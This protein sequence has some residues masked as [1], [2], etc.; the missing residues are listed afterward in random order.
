VDREA[1]SVTEDPRYRVIF[2]ST[3]VLL[4]MIC[5]PVGLE[6]APFA[7]DFNNCLAPQQQGLGGFLAESWDRLGLIRSA[8]FVEIL[9]TTGVC[10]TLPFGVAIALS[11]ALYV[12]VGLALRGLLRDLGIPV[13]WAEI[14]GAL[15]LL[16]PLGTEVALW[17][18]GL[19]VP[20]GLLLTLLALRAWRRGRWILGA[21]AA[22]AACL[23]VEQVILALPLAALLVAPTENRRTA[24]LTTGVIV[25][26][27]A[28][29]FAVFPGNDPR[30]QAGVAE[31]LRGVF[32]DPSFYA[33]YPAVGLGLHSIPLALKWALPWAAVVVGVGAA[34]GYRVLGPRLRSETTRAARWGRD[35]ALLAGLLILLNVPVI[36]NVPRQ[37][38]PRVFAPTWLALAA[39]SAIFGAR[40]RVRSGRALGALIGSV[41]T[42]LLLSIALSVS[43]RT[44]SGDF[45]RWSSG[46]IAESTNDSDVV[47]LCGVRRTVVTTAPRGA[48]AVHDFIYDW[49]AQDAVRYYTDRI[50]T[51]RLGGELLGSSCPSPAEVDVHLEFDRLVTS[52]STR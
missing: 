1:L 32:T 13:L 8:R 49:A 46:R 9:I 38:S 19:H 29:A 39:G 37:G 5:L 25:G 10:Q 48:F 28:V 11:F 35:L 51:F 16:Q 42:G 15:W 3:A 44:D 52:W 24:L 2:W 21:V 22:L 4:G 26:L 41:A 27:V 30:L 31:R 36:L 7:D 20:M 17:P 6:G 45:V 12:G 43:V 40:I 34:T 18:A 14:G 23:S 33:A 47:G 50:V